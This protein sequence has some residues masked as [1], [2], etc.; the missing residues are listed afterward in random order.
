MRTLDFG[1]DYS[2]TIPGGWAGWAF[3]LSL[4]WMLAHLDLEV[5][6]ATETKPVGV[7]PSILGFF[8]I[9]TLVWFAFSAPSVIARWTEGSYPLIVII[10]SL[11]ALGWVLVSLL[12]PQFLERISSPLLLIWNFVFTFCLT[13]TI[14]VHSVPFPPAPDSATVVVGAPAW[15]QAIPLVLMLL[16]FPV[17]FLDLRL[18][19]DQVQH[20]AP[21]PRHL[22]PGILLGSLAL[23]LLIFYQYFHQCMGLC[24]TGQPGFSRQ[25]LASFLFVSRDPH[26]AHLACKKIRTSLPGRNP[27]GTSLGHGPSCWCWFSWAPWSAFSRPNASRS[28]PQAGPHSWS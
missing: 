24:Q 28:T 10:I 12:R 11:L 9:L 25:V 7:T 19:L 14:L 2:L 4:G 16:L 23:I 15:W 6:P 8:L 26:P 13:G 5:K 3:G 18:F 21:S 1:I 17:I 27:A 22:V 20:A